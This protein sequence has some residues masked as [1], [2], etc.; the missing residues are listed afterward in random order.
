MPSAYILANVEVTNAQQYEEYR[1]LS[2]VAMQKH[3]AEVCVRGGKVEVLEGDWSPKRV[4]LL[5]FPTT[6]Q[7]RA[8][9][10]S[11][12]YQAARAARQGAAVMRMV[13]IEGV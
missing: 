3:G 13:L 4:V 9:Y 6:E 5:R 2:T 12:E 10:D 8:F 7:A 1:R 11:A